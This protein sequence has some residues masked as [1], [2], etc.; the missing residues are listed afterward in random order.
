MNQS[1]HS[2]DRVLLVDDDEYLLAALQR[3]LRK[4]YNV[5]TTTSGPKGLCLLEEEQ[6][7][8]VVSDLRMPNM[9]GIE[10]LTRAGQCS[11]NSTR[12]LLTGHADLEAAI[13]AVNESHIFQFLL[14]PI[15]SDKLLRALASGIAQHHLILAEKELLSKT[16]IGSVQI[17]VGL[18]KTVNPDIAQYIVRLKHLARGIALTLQLPNTWQIELAVMLSHVGYIPAPSG[19]LHKILIGA[20]LSSTEQ[21]LL[22]DHMIKASRLLANV[23]RLEAVAEIVG[24]Q[25][26]QFSPQGYLHPIESRDST[27]LS[28][29]IIQTAVR[30]EQ[31]RIRGQSSNTAI[32]LMRLEKLYEPLVLDALQEFLAANPP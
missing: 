13:D 9:D 26:Y 7:A 4:K 6:F 30:Y 16:L 23:P 2:F 10:F 32:G 25:H 29:Q 22:S 24:K 1:D 31:L 20:Q 15:A 8:V 18:L 14:K 19:I 12:I 28:V 21:Q 11:P 3:T 27:T 17:L 5:A